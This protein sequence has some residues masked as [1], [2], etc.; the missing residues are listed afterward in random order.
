MAGP[1][2]SLDCE[3]IGYP[4]AAPAL[5]QPKLRLQPGER[6]AVLGG[7]GA[8]KTALLKT[9]VGLLPARGGRVEIAGV[10]VRGEPARAVS[11]GAG[12]VFQ[13]PDDQLFGA[14]VWEDALFGPHNQGVV[15]EESARRV[16]RAL[17]ELG[18]LPLRD[19]SI[20]ALS[21][22]EKKRAS[23]AGVLAMMPRCSCS[24]NPPLASIRRASS[25]S[26]S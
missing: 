9:L 17:S 26:S 8:G 13:N 20:D 23:L 16:E 22:G 1:A 18:I 24:T 4:G 5:E 25:L 2:L 7:N 14:T 19:R 21:F 6:V 10:D 15:P 11:A 12:L 3:S